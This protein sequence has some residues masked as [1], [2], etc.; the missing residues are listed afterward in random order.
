MTAPRLRATPLA[1][2]ERDGLKAALRKAGL[3][4]DD[5]DQDGHLFWRFETPNDVPVGFGGL[6]IYNSGLG[7]HDVTPVDFSGLGISGRDASL[8][9]FGRDALLRS[10]VIIPPLRR[11]GF[12]AA[13]VESIEQEARLLGCRAIY[14]LTTEPVFFARQGYS[15]CK[16]D[17]MPEAVAA[18]DQFKQQAAEQ[19]ETMVKNLD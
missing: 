18:S 14:L 8:Q 1:A 5:V 17:D 2:F 6:E 12:G 13:I 15:S 9:I 19:T 16:R 4:T 10:I 3:P 7:I 11:Q